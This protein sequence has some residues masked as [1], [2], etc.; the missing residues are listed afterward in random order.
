MYRIYSGPCFSCG[1]RNAWQPEKKV[2]HK[3]I[4]NFIL[5]GAVY[6][7]F[8]RNGTVIG[9]SLCFHWSFLLLFYSS[10]LVHACCGTENYG[11]NHTWHAWQNTM[12]WESQHQALRGVFIAAT[13]KFSITSNEYFP[14]FGRG[15]LKILLVLSHIAETETWW[16]LHYPFWTSITPK[17]SRWTLPAQAPESVPQGISS[18]LRD[19]QDVYS[20]ALAVSQL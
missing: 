15:E 16:V 8:I 20:H 17:D 1:E 10:K 4:H 12:P 5:P 14:L 2:W 13:R 11:S 18:Y 6:L 19:V 7:T 3:N 9:L